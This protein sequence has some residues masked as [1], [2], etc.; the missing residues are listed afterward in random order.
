MTT[1]WTYLLTGSGSEIASPKSVHLTAAIAEVYHG[2]LPGTDEG[3]GSG[4]GGIALR[5]GHDRGPMYVLSIARG[6]LATWEEWANKTYEAE[7]CPAREQELSEQQ[8]FKLMSQILL[9]NIDR[10]RSA[11]ADAVEK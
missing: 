6:G 3:E 10:V 2:H 9:G 11:F 1:A 5:S 7:L 4:A 8:A